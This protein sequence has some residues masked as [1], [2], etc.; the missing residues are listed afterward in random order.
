MVTSLSKPVQSMEE[1]VKAE[2]GGGSSLQSIVPAC[3]QGL[4][5][6]KTDFL[7]QDFSVDNFFIEEND[8]NNEFIEFYTDGVLT[9]QCQ[10]GW[11][12]S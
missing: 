10:R 9:G 7:K 12:Q 8:D 2:E 5:I 6:N 11:S 4:C 1:T 3:P